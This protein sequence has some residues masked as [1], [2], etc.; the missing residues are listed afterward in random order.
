[1][2]KKAEL[3]R[4]KIEK[5]EA[6][7]EKKRLQAIKTAELQRVK[8]EMKEAAAEKKRLQAIKKEEHR[9]AVEERKRQRQQKK[10]ENVAKKNQPDKSSTKKLMSVRKP[11]REV[12]EFITVAATTEEQ[13]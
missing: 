7:A 12:Q 8:I 2:K 10:S 1:M 6:A 4:V 13:S 3:Q 5:K 9:V 11:K